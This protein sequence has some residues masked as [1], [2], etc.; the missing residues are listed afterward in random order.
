M[1]AFRIVAIRSDA[2]V[3]CNSV[4]S[5]MPQRIKTQASTTVKTPKR[6]AVSSR[7]AIKR[8]PN[9]ANRYW[10]VLRSGVRTGRRGQATGA[11]GGDGSITPDSSRRCWAGGIASPQQSQFFEGGLGLF[12]QKGHS[13]F[14]R[15]SGGP[16]IA[17]AY[18][19][20]AAFRHHG[21]TASGG[22]W[23]SSFST[24]YC[25]LDRG[26]TPEGERELGTSRGNMV[27]DSVPFPRRSRFCRHQRA[28]NIGAILP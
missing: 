8:S 19:S 22:R 21:R 23:P 9:L 26:E 28:K 4:P 25:N 24:N 16:P 11:G 20:R 3:S 5:T 18:P 1:A 13:M 12:W 2:V 7:K 15:E 10:L 27:N 6:I 14:L 17:Q